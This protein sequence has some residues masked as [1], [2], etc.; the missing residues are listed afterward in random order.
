MIEWRSLTV[1]GP[2]TKFHRTRD[3]LLPEHPSCGRR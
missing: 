3:T 2:P 1:A